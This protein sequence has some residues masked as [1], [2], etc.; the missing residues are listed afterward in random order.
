MQHPD[1]SE[2]PPQPQSKAEDSGVVETTT[3]EESRDSSK[4]SELASEQEIQ[5]LLEEARIMAA[6]AQQIESMASQLLA[7]GGSSEDVNQARQ[8]A[9]TMRAASEQVNTAISSAPTDPKT[10]KN[11]ISASKVTALIGSLD[12]IMVEAQ[13]EEREIASETGTARSSHAKAFAPDRLTARSNSKISVNRVITAALTGEG[14][15]QP[16]RQSEANQD[17]AAFKPAMDKD[18]ARNHDQHVDAREVAGAVVGIA[19][20][21]GSAK[22]RATARR[23][24]DEISEASAR[25]DRRGMLDGALHFGRG[26]ANVTGSDDV[27]HVVTNAVGTTVTKANTAANLVGEGKLA[28]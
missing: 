1:P 10:G 2:Q 4:S 24:M 6:K 19:R 13:S 21:A 16:H 26:V 9:S 7:D 28:I 15:A 25:N 3:R 12:H 17:D 11:R 27:G 20:A 8:Q 5:T 23:I 22:K 18:D 14:K